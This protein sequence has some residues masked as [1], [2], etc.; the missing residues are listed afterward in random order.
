MSIH[1]Q[2][3]EKDGVKEFVILPYEEFLQIQEEL[4]DFEDLKTLREE[5]IWASGEP[6]RSL[7][8]VLQEIGE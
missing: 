4:E 2:I 6:S 7:D 5:R 8:D 1:P 3:I